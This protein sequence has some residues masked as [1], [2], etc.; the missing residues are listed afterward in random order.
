MTI[1]E[2]TILSPEPPRPGI[3][4]RK[5][6][7][8][9]FA[10][11]IVALALISSLLMSGTGSAPTA[12]RDASELRQTGKDQPLL[13]EEAAAARPGQAGPLPRR[14]ASASVTPLPGGTAPGPLPPE[15]RRDDSVGAIFDRRAPRRQGA[16]TAGGA[17]AGADPDLEQEAAVRLAK[18]LIHDFDERPA[19][20]GSGSPAPGAAGRA[21]RDAAGAAG[22]ASASAEQAPAMPSSYVNAQ[23]ENLKNQ[24]AGGQPA[25]RADQAWYKDYARDTGDVRRVLTATAKPRGLVLQQGKIIPAVLGRQLNSDLPGRITAYVSANV[26]DAEGRLVIP[27]GAALVGRYDAGV[28]VGQSRLMF[29]FERLILPGGLSFDLPAAPGT[30]L[31]GA[32]GA[33]GDVNNH[34]LKMFGSSLLIA[35]LAD[36]TRQPTSVTQVGGTGP[37]TAAGQVLSD[38]SKASLERNRGIP[39]TI[40]VEQ[41]TRINVEVVADMVFPDTVAAR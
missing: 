11:L 7:L 38:V 27:K 24:L 15:V 31:A 12:V 40:T 25:T 13:D 22:A 36:H 33:T 37:A 29:A 23:M 16:S 3:P 41:G 32:A 26:Y 1:S 6:T 5:S 28:R 17:A 35:L 20:S 8:A 9:V 2:R 34:F 21:G 30:D 18:A 10:A 19:E 4:L 39:P 14:A